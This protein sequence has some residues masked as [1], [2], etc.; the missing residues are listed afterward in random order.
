[1]WDDGQRTFLRYPGNRGTPIAYQVL[2]DGTEA[3]VGQ[4]VVVDPATKG[5]LLI[6]HK[7]VP[8]LRL[9]DGTSVVCIT[10]NAYDPTGTNS[11][12][13]TVDPGIVRDVKGP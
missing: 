4:N 7:V 2:A 11:G 5:S 13:G 1:M 3:T 6:L 12:T 10:N 8:M 9:R